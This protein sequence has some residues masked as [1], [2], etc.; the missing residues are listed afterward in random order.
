MIVTDYVLNGFYG[1]RLVRVNELKSGNIPIDMVY[2][3][4]HG[5]DGTAPDR[6]Q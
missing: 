6:D 3:G 2:F 1:E 5:F 4:K